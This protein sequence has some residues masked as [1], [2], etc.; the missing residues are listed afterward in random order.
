MDVDC[1]DMGDTLDFNGLDSFVDSLEA[2]CPSKLEKEVEWGG[3]W[4]TAL[5]CSAWEDVAS[6]A[7]DMSMDG[8]N[9]LDDCCQPPSK[10]MKYHH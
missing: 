1:F 8:L 10:F 7:M 3:S 6:M 2:S 4:E 9:L 5:C